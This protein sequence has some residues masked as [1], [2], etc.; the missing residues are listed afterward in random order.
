MDVEAQDSG[1]LAKILVPDGA[2]KVDVGRPIA[3]LAD[4]GDDISA[5][6]LP[7]QEDRE[8]AQAAVEIESET[9][10]KQDTTTIHKDS[11]SYQLRHDLGNSYSPSVLHLLHQ[12]GIEDPG[13]IPA[14]GPQGRLLKGDVLAQVGTI[15]PDIPRNLKTILDKKR[16]LDTSNVVIQ[17]SP[18]PSEVE[19]PTP[20][21]TASASPPLAHIDTIVQFKE[22]FNVHR[23]QSG[24]FP[25]SASLLIG[26]SAPSN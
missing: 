22:P 19:V 3:I 8:P 12:Y 1:V 11:K 2:Q 5:L 7:D 6:Q 21:Y 25:Y 24:A 14:T 9:Q 10:Q 20:R 18:A 4:Q 15:A 26:R 17:R 16:G 23:D 13:S